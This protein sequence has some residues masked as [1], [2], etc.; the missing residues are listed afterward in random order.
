M[1]FGYTV[2]AILYQSTR[3]GIDAFLGKAILGLIQCFIFNWLYFEV[4]GSNLAMHAIR[5]HKLSAMAWSMSHLPFIMSFVL[6]GAALSRLVISDMMGA[7]RC[8]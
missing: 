2:V 1:V 6:G 8:T 4:D 7:R 3:N 5:R